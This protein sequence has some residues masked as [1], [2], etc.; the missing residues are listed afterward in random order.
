MVM[1]FFERISNCDVRNYPEMVAAK[2][3]TYI[4]IEIF[5]YR[6]ILLQVLEMTFFVE[7]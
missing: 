3:Y 1:L 6:S 5:Q 7:K 2:D 4:V